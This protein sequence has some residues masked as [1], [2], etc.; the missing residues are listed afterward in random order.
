MKFKWDKKYTKIA[1]YAILVIVISGVLLLSFQVMPDIGSV[2]DSVISVFTP[3]LWGLVIAYLL[4]PIMKTFEFRVFGGWRQKVKT[5]AARRRI[6]SLSIFLTVILTLTAF[7]GILWLVLPQLASSV[8][9]VAKRFPE[10]VENLRAWANDTFKDNPQIIDFLADPLSQLETYLQSIWQSAQ[11][12]ITS[13]LTDMGSS[14]WGILLGLKDFIIGFI[15]AVYLLV[16]KDMFAVQVKKFMFAFFKN[17]FCLKSF[18]IYHRS[19]RIFQQYISGVLLD[20]FLVGCMTFI[21]ATCIGAP[22]PLLLAVIIA[23]TNFIPFFGPFI[24]GIPATL[25]VLMEDPLKAVLFALF[26]LAMQQF[27]G[28]ILVPL[29]QGDRTG[30]P[31]VWVLLAIIV[32]GGMFGFAG[33]LL[34]VPV[35]AVIYMLSKDYINARLKRKSLPTSTI[36]YRRNIEAM[37]DDFVYTDEMKQK[38]EEWIRNLAQADAKPNRS[39]DKLNELNDRFTR[40]ASDDSGEKASDGE[41]SADGVLNT[42]TTQDNKKERESK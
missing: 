24:G 30:V 37:D 28:N 17:S 10:Y 39:L 7:S 6:H 23:I 2:I 11:P 40:N 9:N 14:V 29:I 42:D 3:I 20:A 4:N 21:G 35:F 25:L 33:M 12:G 8:L 15:I 19:N 5:Q 34:A 16:T 27:D 41:N 22:F 31:S 32:G 1:I 36:L 38:D 26:M 18:D 13:F